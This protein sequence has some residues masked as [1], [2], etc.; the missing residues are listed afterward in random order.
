MK[1][2]DEF[3]ANINSRPS[4]ELINFLAKAY[5]MPDKYRVHA[6]DN[7]DTVVARNFYLLSVLFAMYVTCVREIP[8]EK[9]LEMDDDGRKN[10]MNEFIANAARITFS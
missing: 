6:I 2:D 9:I 8:Y 5:E 10:L 1:L 4:T 7:F 3:F